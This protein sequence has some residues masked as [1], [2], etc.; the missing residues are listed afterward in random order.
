MPK[1]AK[2]DRGQVVDKALNL[3]WAR[4][5]HAT[6]MRNLQE[7]VDMRPGSVYATFGS[8]EGLFKE[9]LQRYMQLGIEHLNDCC[10]Q[11]GSPLQGLKQFVYQILIEKR[12]S[13]PN[14]M[15][16]LAKTVSELTDENALLL[17]QAKKSLKTIEAEFERVLQEA[18]ALGEVDKAKDCKQLAQHIQVQISGLRTYATIHDGDLPLEKMIEDLFTHYPF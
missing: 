13:A 16:M 7:V 17:A 11:T 5:F 10:Q 3:Y 4:G 2:F 6:S 9:A 15:C 12:S 14:T 1:K 18:Q 8:K